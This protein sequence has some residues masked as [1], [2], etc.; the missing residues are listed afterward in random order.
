MTTLLLVRHGES[1]ANEKDAFIGH[2]DLDLTARGY[3]QARMTA[4]FIA[5]NY[6]V[7]RLYG[8]DLQRA[9]HTGEAIASRLQLPIIKDAGLREIYAGEWEGKTFDELDVE[10]VEDYEL[11]KN[12][13]GNSFCTGGESVKHLA[14]RIY[15]AFSEIARR[16]DGETVV[17]ATHATPIRAMLTLLS[18]KT[19][20]EMCLVPWPT[21]ASVTEVTYDQGVWQVVKASQDAHLKEMKTFVAENV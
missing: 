3:T 8:S 20:D 16:H 5:E 15:A 12:D 17:L 1:E 11:W 13:I 14:E 10:Y 9:F 2:T 21:N 18:G 19:L 6:H 7:D 4:D